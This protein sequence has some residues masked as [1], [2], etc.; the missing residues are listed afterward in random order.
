M[1]GQLRLVNFVQGVLYHD[2]VWGGTVRNGACLI[3]RLS[4][5]QHRLFPRPHQRLRRLPTATPTPTPRLR[6]L[7]LP[8][9]QQTPTP[10]PTPT[11][12]PTTTPQ[13]IDRAIKVAANVTVTQVNYN[14][15]NNRLYLAI[16][17]SGVNY[18][19]ATI[20]KTT[21]PNVTILRVY[22]NSVQTSYTY[23]DNGSAWKVTIITT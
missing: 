23:T 22:V 6:L 16:T 3:L 12:T 9:Q 14:Q 2:V 4:P 17:K 20:S 5:R 11:A 15:A 8:P 1:M 21:L 18:I 7:R 10:S 19:E 13:P